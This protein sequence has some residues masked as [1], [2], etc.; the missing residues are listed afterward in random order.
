MTYITLTGLSYTVLSM[1]GRQD[2]KMSFL[3]Q[4]QGTWTIP[5]VLP[6][7][8][9]QWYYVVLPWKNQPSVGLEGIARYKLHAAQARE[10]HTVCISRSAVF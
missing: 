8:N 7:Q 6:E 9:W 2:A 3:L 10:A 4:C 1:L 5:S